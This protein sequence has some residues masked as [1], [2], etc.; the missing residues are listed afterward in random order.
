MTWSTIGRPSNKDTHLSVYNLAMP[1][2]KIS[3][4]IIFLINKKVRIYIIAVS[5]GLSQNIWLN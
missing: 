3:W 4:I 5:Y 1:T 2:E